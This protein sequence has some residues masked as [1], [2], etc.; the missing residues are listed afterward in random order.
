[1]SLYDTERTSHYFFRNTRWI[2]S[3]YFKFLSLSLSGEVLY[4]ACL[5]TLQSTIYTLKDES[6]NGL[7]FGQAFRHVTWTEH[8]ATCLFVALKKDLI[9]EQNLWPHCH[10]DWSSLL[11]C[12]FKLSR[13]PEI[14]PLSPDKSVAML[15]STL[16]DSSTPF[17]PLLFLGLF[18]SI[19]SFHWF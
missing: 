6:H 3:N 18:V 10:L 12:P 15:A 17:S 8:F 5:L 4:V 11:Q 14:M 19:R 1:M 9:D 13:K 2:S 16:L 7:L